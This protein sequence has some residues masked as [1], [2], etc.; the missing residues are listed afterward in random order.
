MSGRSVG[1]DPQRDVADQLGL[2]PAE[3]L[4]GGQLLP[5]GAGQRRGVDA[6]G[7]G[8]AGLVHG[9]DRE[10]PGVVGVGQRLADGDLGHAGHRGDLARAGLLALDPVEGVGDEQIGDLGP[11]D[12]AV[13]LAPRHRGPLGERPVVDPAHGQPAEVGGGVEVGHDGLQRRALLVVGCGDAVEDGLEQ[14]LEVGALDALLGGGPAG[15]GVGEED[16]EV[17]LVLVGVEVEEE[18]LHLVDDLVDAGVGPV[19]LVDHEHHRQPGLEGLAEHEP[20]LGEGALGG[21]DQQEHAVDHGQATLDLAAEVGVARGVDD[22]DLHAVV[23]HGGVLGEDGDA[24]LALEVAGVHDPLVDRLV[25]PEGTGLPEH[26]VHQG[27]LP[28][29]DVGH[30]GHVADVV[31][32]QD[33]HG[34]SRLAGPQVAADG[35]DSQ[36]DRAGPPRLAWPGGAV[37]RSPRPGQGVIGARRRPTTARCRWCWWP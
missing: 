14:R 2:E 1:F 33:G 10:R 26:G 27:G 37:D 22:V 18:L 34:G 30:D 23:E 25:V 24:L 29:V 16:R 12:G 32:G 17:D 20:G 9:D 5:V 31:T 4:S 21:V 19:D 11:L 28:V 3:D 13:E 36:P 35:S 15:P 8:Q 7:H 6:D